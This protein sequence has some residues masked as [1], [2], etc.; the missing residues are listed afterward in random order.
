MIFHSRSQNIDW[1]LRH[2]K[3]PG[4][5]GWV[6]APGGF[7]TPGALDS[8]HWEE[9]V[10]LHAKLALP[11]IVH[12]FPSLQCHSSGTVQNEYFYFWPLKFLFFLV[13]RDSKAGLWVFMGKEKFPSVSPNCRA[14]MSG[15]RI[16][17]Y[18]QLPLSPFSLGRRGGQV[19]VV[20]KNSQDGSDKHH[21]HPLIFQGLNTGT[22]IQSLWL[23]SQ[24]SGSRFLVWNLNQTI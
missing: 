7:Q 8:L 2:A 13:P 24:D 15:L 19:C 23:K 22:T 6:K 3:A 14:S 10:C 11:H 17:L 9:P 20:W 16:F 12:I 4:F 18:Q 5:P 21:L 1:L